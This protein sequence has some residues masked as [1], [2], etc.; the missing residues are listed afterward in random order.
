MST[1]LYVVPAGPFL[2]FAY[3]SN[4]SV[5]RLHRS[6]PSARLVTIARLEGHRL[7]FTRE[8]QAWRGGVADIRPQSGTETWGA[9]WLIDADESRAL[10]AQEGLFRDPPAY[11]RI[12]VEVTTPAGDLVRCRSYQV[13]EPADPEL[14]P[15][16][17]YLETLLGGARALP[18]PAA[19]VTLLETIQ[20]NGEAGG[21]PA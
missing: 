18:L 9:L 13:V 20:D 2:Y 12:T 6:C 4:L 11:R 5:D 14:R 15:S 19:Y 17:A 16:P 8:S 21:A 7:A 3:G 1:G 10:D